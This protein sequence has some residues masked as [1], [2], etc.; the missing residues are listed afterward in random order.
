MSVNPPTLIALVVVE[1]RLVTVCN[2]SVL[3]Y[4]LLIMYV[5]PLTATLIS[6]VPVISNDP[7][8]KSTLPVVVPSLNS[9]VISDQV[10]ALPDLGFV[11]T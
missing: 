10:T 5:E 8:V 4:V 9:N 7:V 11:Y 6:P 2:E 1:P 3:E